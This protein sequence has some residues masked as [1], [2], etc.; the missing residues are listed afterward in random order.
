MTQTINSSAPSGNL[1][2][3]WQIIR[4]KTLFASIC[5]V[6]AAGLLLFENK[7]V[8]HIGGTTVIVFVV[9]L[10]SALSLQVLSNLINDYY[11]FKKG[12]DKKGRVGF[13]RALAEGLVTPLQMK[14]A[15]YITL[16]V[17]ILTGAL[18]IVVGG[19]PIVLI[20]ISA[21]VFAWLYTAT[22]HSLSYLGIADVFCFLYY[23]VFA[24]LGTKY[25][26]DCTMMTDTSGLWHNTASA[27]KSTFCVGAICG[28]ISMMVLMINNLR[29]M[30]DDK[31]ANKKTIPVRFGKKFGESLLLIYSLLVLSL[32]FYAFGLSFTNMLFVPFFVIYQKITVAQGDTYNQL[33]F[34]S[35]QLNLLFVI[36][37][38]LEVFI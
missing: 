29:D 34:K 23:G 27:N 36:L 16:G 4:P 13:K 14:K 25:L 37:L 20:G 31:A 9:T 6:I 10:L 24:V 1:R 35:G 7:D 18:L 19:L 8:E 12:S 2:L 28:M 5:P 32:S 11:D 22:P 15:I 21:M 26:V 30:E 3:W 38:A 17:A 33:L